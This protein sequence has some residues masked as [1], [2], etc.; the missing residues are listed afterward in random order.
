MGIEDLLPPAKHSPQV[1]CQGQEGADGNP[2]ADR[3]YVRGRAGPGGQ[4]RGATRNGTVSPIRESDHELVGTARGIERKHR[5][6]L[7][8]QSMARVDHGDVRDQP[9][10]NCGI[11]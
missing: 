6:G 8:M 11:P 4:I 9:F 5:Q 7:S 1:S 10:R 3:P 2:R